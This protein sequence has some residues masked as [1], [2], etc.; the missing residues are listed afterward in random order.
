MPDVARSASG[1]TA[2]SWELLYRAAG[3]GEPLRGYYHRNYRVGLPADL[4]DAVALPAGT[5]VKVRAP[6]PDAVQFNLRIWPE[7]ELLRAIAG[8]VD[9]SPRVLADRPGFTVY[10]FA[11]GAPLSGLSGGP[12]RFR[13][14]LL[15][16]L[17][18]SGGARHRPPPGYAAQLEALF[19]QTAAV[20]PRS[21]PPLPDGWPRDGDCG[22]FLRTLI[23]FTE[24]EVK[25]RS[26]PAHQELLAVLGVDE[27]ALGRLRERA[28]G[29][30]E[31]PF[32]L[33]HTDTHAGN[34][35]LGP[36]G[37]LSLID[38]ELAL[39]GDPVYEI[40]AH[41]ARMRYAT[42]GR[43]RAALR[44]WRSAVS[45][46]CPGALTG[47]RAALRVYLDFER[48]LSVHIDVIRLTL[49]LPQ[50]AGPPA[51]AVTAERIAAVLAAAQGPLGLRKV[52]GADRI[53]AACGVW[54]RD[55]R[56]VRRMRNGRAEVDVLTYGQKRPEGKRNVVEGPQKWFDAV[57]TA[58]GS[59]MGLPE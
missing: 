44:A 43:R 32:T 30:G 3:E 28:A 33:L 2:D 50:R 36:G 59:D 54:Q 15:P 46:S 19:R 8:R 9:G 49:D 20:P 25:G 35:I 26:S 14:G 58:N 41:L 13:A 10:S 6:I 42:G 16:L 7:G 4:A 24:S 23:D 55:E 12:G 47:H 56:E 11:Q 37:E 34:L 57:R 51:L 39:F 48:L 38:W 17:P 31:R 5:P 53:A 1:R 29:L 21:L 27:G 45:A 52:P 18:G 40:A 22:G